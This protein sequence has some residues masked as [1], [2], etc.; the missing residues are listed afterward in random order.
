M[1]ARLRSPPSRVARTHRIRGCS[2]PQAC[3]RARPAA[4]PCASPLG[5]RH[6]SRRA[7]PR[8]CAIC[9]ERDCWPIWRRSALPSSASAA[10]PASVTPARSL[11][12]SSQP[13]ARAASFRSP[14][15]PA[16][17]I[18]PAGSIRGSRA[19]F[20]G[21]PPLVV[22]FALAGDV[23]RNILTDPLG[24]TAAGVP[25]RLADIWPTGAEIDA[26]LAQARDPRDYPEAYDQAERS[27][28][29]EALDAADSALFP[30][31]EASTY[32]RRPPFTAFGDDDTSRLLPRP[33]AA[34]ARR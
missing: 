22:A 26:A 13:W 10:P 16:T 19:A 15:S 23:N 6:R 17:A 27:A 33:S 32:L 30:W 18:S 14:Y 5:S 21:S 1:T 2:S 29:W 31:D 25:V 11:L 24:H 9:S 20:L 34:R 3:S 28:P 8:R 7:H 4:R 12:P